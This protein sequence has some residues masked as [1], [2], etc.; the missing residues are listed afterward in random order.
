M[1]ADVERLYTQSIRPLP[2]PARLELLA[3]IAADLATGSDNGATRERS[4]LEL[5]GLGATLWEAVDAQSYVND[6]RNEWEQR[7]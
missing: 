4:L 5:E 1:Q 7:P 6:L 2:L 3:R